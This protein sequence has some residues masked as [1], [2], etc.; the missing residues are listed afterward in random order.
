M[1]FGFYD[2]QS[3]GDWYREVSAGVGML[4]DLVQYWI[5]TT[6]LLVT[7][8]APHFSE[9]IWT[10]ILENPQSIQLAIWPTPSDPV[11]LTLIEASQYM[12]GTIKI[13]RD[14]EVSLLK[15]LTKAKG[16]KSS[17]DAFYDPK[18]PK[19]VRIYVATAFPEWHWQD[20]CANHQEAYSKEEDK[21]GDAKVKQLLTERELIKDKSPIPF[22]QAF[23]VC[24]IARNR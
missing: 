3:T 14:A 21:V 17:I 18:K 6:T 9:H 8:I 22:I 11:E 12:C 13:I 10:T 23:K 16:K 5:R 15:A 24:R 20:T 4:H 1:K 7:P 19:A 2:F